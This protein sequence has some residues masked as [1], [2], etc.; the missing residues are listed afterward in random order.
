M[1]KGRSKTA[2]QYDYY[3]S[4]RNDMLAHIPESTKT[5]LEIGCG[6][7]EF[8]RAIQQKCSAEV[9]GV[10][11]FA[12]AAEQARLTLHKV[13]VG[14]IEQQ[15]NNLP[16]RYFDCICMN[17]VIEHLLN[18]W[19]VLSAL[20][21]K[22]KPNG[23]IVASIPNIRHY[24]NLHNLLIGADWLYTDAG[25]LDRT[26][27]RFFTHKS[28]QRLFE[29]SGY[30]INKIQGVKKSRKFKLKFLNFISGGKFWDIAYLHFAVIAT[31]AKVTAFAAN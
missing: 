28:M 22:L 11:L 5:V 12:E 30:T 17:D 23:I 27:L 26:H 14:P 16:D 6:R 9:W 25:I 7:G 18:P 13:F 10:E 19:Q 3:G 20:K 31:P 21:T 24:K 29:E 1:K 4:A 15:L 8:S 2:K